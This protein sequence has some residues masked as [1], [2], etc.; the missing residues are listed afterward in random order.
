MSINNRIEKYLEELTKQ[1]IGL[2]FTSQNLVGLTEFLSCHLCWIGL[3]NTNILFSKKDV[4]DYLKKLEENHLNFVSQQQ[5][6]YTQY[7]GDIGIVTT[8]I[9]GYFASAKEEK[10]TLCV[11]VIWNQNKKKWQ[12]VHIHYSLLETQNLSNNTQSSYNHIEKKLIDVANTDQLT[13]IYNMNGFINQSEKT[14]KENPHQKYALVKFGIKNFR[15]INRKHSYDV[16]NRVLKNIAKNIKQSCNENEICGRIEKDMFAMLYKYSTKEEMDTRMDE[17]RETL[18]DQE[19]LNNIEMVIHFTAGIYISENTAEENVIDM[20]DKALIAQQNV[21]K[22][23][24]GS[25]YRYYEEKMIEGQFY[26][27]QILNLAEK[28]MNNH[29]FKLYIQPQF[30]IKT[31]QVIAGEVLCR[32]HSND[33]EIIYP[34]EFITLFEENG[35]VQQLD[36]YMLDLL[37][38]TLRK[39]ID[40]GYSVKPLSLNQSR[41]NIDDKNYFRKFCSVVDFYK[42]PHN[43]ITF[44]LTESVF[45]EQTSDILRLANEI[46]KQ[47]FMLAIDDF[48]TG[49]ASFNTLNDMYA[50]ILKIDKSLLNDVHKN[51]RARSIIEKVIELAHDIEMLVICEGIETEEQLNYLKDIHCDIGQGYLVGKAMPAEEFKQR[52]LSLEI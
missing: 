27:S 48:G 25:H 30:D 7:L 43:L 19:I 16:G 24:Q 36:F 52:Y 45:V 11:T 32:W 29:E 31:K 4:L 40:E 33:K 6:Y 22:K 26:N 9:D 13:N 37:C 44:E 2:Y 23:L 39:W 18:V 50:N 41:F 3:N 34:N 10:K 15:Y 20:L 47:K 1:S 8:V 42:I 17:V 28:A 14:F 21:S 12:I 51:Q 35:L 46:H 38:Q 5:Y 49:F